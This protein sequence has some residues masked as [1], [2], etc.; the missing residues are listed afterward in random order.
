MENLDSMEK[1]IN[2]ISLFDGISCGQLALQRAGIKVENYFASEIDKHAIKVAMKNFPDTIQLG[3][4][5]GV[6]YT[7]G[8]EDTGIL[9]DDKQMYYTVYPIDLV[10]AGS[11]CQGFSFAGKQLNFEDPRSK[12]F[13]EFVRILKEIRVHNPDVKFLL[14]NVKMKKEYQD[15]IS[16]YLGVQPIEINSSLVSAQNR[17]RLYWTNIENIQQPKDKNILLKDIIETGFIDR[18]KNY[19]IDANY[20][21]GGNLKQY[22]EKSRRQLVFEAKN[23]KKVTINPEDIYI[24]KTFYETRTEMGKISRKEIRH[25]TGLD[26]TPRSKDHKHYILQNHEK[27]NCL[28]TV[29]SFLNWVIDKD[30]YCRKLSVIECER[31]QTLPDLWTEGISDSQRYKALGNGWTVDVIAHIFKNL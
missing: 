20:W 13:F 10:L 22:F 6:E 23:S 8:G 3:D 18:N 12:L 9:S 7:S 15:V 26:S 30:Y 11:P 28:V 19:C 14:E 27:A 25:R 2:A 24:P 17:K 5:R 31:L 21:K 4:I 29:D 1:G 16:E